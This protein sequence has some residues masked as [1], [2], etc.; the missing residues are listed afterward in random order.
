VNILG[1]LSRTICEIQMPLFENWRGELEP[2][3]LPTLSQFSEEIELES[4]NGRNEKI[5]TALGSDGKEY[6]FRMEPVRRGNDSYAEEFEGLLMS[7]V[8]EVGN[9]Q[10]GFWREALI[11]KL[12]LIG[13]PKIFLYNCQEEVRMARSSV[14]ALTP[15]DILGEYL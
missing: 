15:V 6:R 3:S 2:N 5:L 1:A 7:Q 14:H 8:L 12:K 9:Q 13:E 4:V 10:L 11:R